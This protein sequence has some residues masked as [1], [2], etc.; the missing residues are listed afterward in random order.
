MLCEMLTSNDL[1]MSNKQTSQEKSVLLKFK[2]LTATTLWWV[3]HFPSD[4]IICL[5]PMKRW[6]GNKCSCYHMGKKNGQNYFKTVENFQQCTRVRPFFVFTLH[7]HATNTISFPCTVQVRP[8]FVTLHFHTT[9]TINFP[10]TV[11]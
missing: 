10:R 11:H 8:F 1:P 9:N 2:P 5:V 6:Q 7:F 3:K 4:V